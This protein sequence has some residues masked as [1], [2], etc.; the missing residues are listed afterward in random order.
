MLCTDQSSRR[1]R[2]NCLG[3]SQAF[4]IAQ[5]VEHGKQDPNP[6]TKVVFCLA[7]PQERHRRLAGSYKGGDFNG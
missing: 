3:L 2:F 6:S 4:P 5:A 7:D 1:I